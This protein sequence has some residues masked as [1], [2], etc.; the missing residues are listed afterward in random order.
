[1]ASPKSLKSKIRTRYQ[2][3]QIVKLFHAFPLNYGGNIV[4]PPEKH[5]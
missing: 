3:K 2:N 4:D 5:N 1:M